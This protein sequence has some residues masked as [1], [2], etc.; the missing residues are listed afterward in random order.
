[1]KIYNKT[2]KWYKNPS[3][4]KI[5]QIY[6]KGLEYSLLSDNDHQC[7]PFVWCK[8]FIHDVIYAS[9][10]KTEFKA[11]K[12]HYNPNLNPNPSLKKAKILIADSKDENFSKRINNVLDFLNQFENKIK[13]KPSTIKKCK[14]APEQ[15]EKNGV[16][17][18]EGDKRWI[19]S[20]P[21]VSLYT[22]LIR[23][24]FSHTIKCDFLETIDKI[25]ANKLQTYQKKDNYWLKAIEPAIEKILNFGDQN[26]FLKDMKS[27]YPPKL[28]P[29]I[30][31]NKLGIIGYSNDIVKKENNISVVIPDWHKS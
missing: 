8:D 24:G 11:Y 15:Y 10:N 30:V 28:K 31:H 6:K 22:L 7:H 3:E 13:I 9:I 27:N 20:P 21:M 29:N 23:V 2:I 18:V 26:I 1:M 19:N 4:N 12:F 14:K 25:K 5:F 16:Y 17:L